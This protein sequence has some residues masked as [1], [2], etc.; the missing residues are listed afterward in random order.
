MWESDAPA[1]DSDGNFKDAEDMDFAFSATE[2]DPPPA[3]HI[4]A[5]K[6]AMDS[7][8]STA[9]PVKSQCFCRLSQCNVLT[10]LKNDA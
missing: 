3:G 5:S 9:Q 2:A 7:Q 6:R 4:T 8:D 10:F 1:L